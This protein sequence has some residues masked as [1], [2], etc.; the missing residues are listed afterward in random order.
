MQVTPGT[1][2]IKLEAAWRAIS[3]DYMESCAIFRNMPIRG[4][5]KGKAPIVVTSSHFSREIY[6]DT[7]RRCATRLARL[8][9]LEKGIRTVGPLLILQSSFEPGQKFICTIEMLLR[10]DVSVPDCRDF[11][12]DAESKEARR[13]E[14]KQWL[15]SHADCDM[16]EPII[17][18]CLEP[19][20][21]DT[22]Q[23][24]SAIWDN[25]MHDALLHVIAHEVADQH[26]IIVSEQC[27]QNHLNE[28]AAAANTTPEILRINYNRNGQ[29]ETVREYLLI[30]EV[31]DFLAKHESARASEDGAMAA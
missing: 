17:R 7:I 16:P 6:A 30:E 4:Y 9:L 28:L 8:V 18:R 31:L 2:R 10:P 22:A 5:P 20:R 23:P 1:I 26:D 13:T 3:A 11:A 29:I 19:S 12:S 27:L 24:G 15:F 21:H 14:L 25:A